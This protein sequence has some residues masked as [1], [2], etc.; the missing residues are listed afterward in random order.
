MLG[1][2]PGLRAL[3][4]QPKSQ[5]PQVQVISLPDSLSFPG[6]CFPSVGNEG[7]LRLTVPETRA[8]SRPSVEL[9]QRMQQYRGAC[10]H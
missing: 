2:T 10:R 9:P 5:W 4:Y 8:L 6:E 7:S 1:V 3:D